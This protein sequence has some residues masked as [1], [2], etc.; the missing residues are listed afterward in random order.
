MLPVMLLVIFVIIELARLLYAW[1]A[2]ENAARFGIRYLVTGGYDAAMCPAPCTTQPDW[3][4]ARIVSVNLAARAGS[5]G[6]LRDDF[7]TWPFPGFY[8]V[9]ICGSADLLNS[10]PDNWI[11]DWS[12]ICPGGD[13]PGDPGETATV[14]VDF[15]HPLIVPL[16]SSWW[17]QLH[18]TA[19]RDGIIEAFRVSRLLGAGGLPTAVS[20]NT[21]TP[22]RTDTPTVTLTPTDT[23][24]PTV[25]LTPTET[26]TITQTPTVTN[27]P[28]GTATPDCSL[29][30][31][32]GYD[33]YDFGGFQYF[34]V[35]VQNNNPSNIFLT[36]SYLV[37]PNWAGMYIDWFYYSG[38]YY[39]GDDSNSPTSAAPVPPRVLFAGATS[40]WFAGIGNTSPNWL[41]GTWTVTLTFDNVCTVT[42]SATNL[43]PTPTRTPTVTQTPTVTLTPTVTPTPTITPT[44][45]VT[46]TP[47]ETLLPTLTPTVT[48]TPTI[49][50]T[51]TSTLTQTLTPT[52]DCSLLSV[53]GMWFSG[54]NIYMDVRNDNPSVVYLTQA[55]FNWT[56]AYGSQY[57]DW[58][59]FRGTT[60]DNGNDSTPPTNRTLGSPISLLSGQIGTWR[61]DFDGVPGNL[62]LDGTF[63][64]S[65]IFDGV[66]VAGSSI[67]RTAPTVTNTPPPTSTR[68]PTRT[69][70]PSLTPTRTA[71]A[72]PTNT[73]TPTPT[74]TPWPTFDDT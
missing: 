13:Y 44:R 23:A 36:D 28:T 63:S 2:V 22:T 46:P 19:R 8:K 42:G 32:T 15:N 33:F 3:D 60:Y 26:S 52:P 67:S 56:K 14:N 4:I 11:T 68:T 57:V 9:T 72:G 18:L 31:I 21:T 54:D 66:C 16:L 5:A 53:T 69:L 24:T 71:T 50:L 64:V 51:P 10:D 6:V 1:I 39:N 37:W 35:D 27:T 30:S 38:Y 41:F 73:V 70:L 29:I 74:N 58:I 48:R 61:V 62:G 45:T 59:Q 17:P 20:T 34:Y 40:Q 49:T 12:A 47:T 25:S 43:T 7:E 55:N 65:L